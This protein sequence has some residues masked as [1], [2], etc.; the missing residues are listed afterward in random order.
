MGE[1][2]NEPS[3]D[4]P[5]NNPLLTMLFAAV[6]LNVDLLHCA[7]PSLCYSVETSAVAQIQHY[8]RA[9]RLLEL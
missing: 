8:A 7:Q 5:P 1:P 4:P 6:D 9:A 3:P 2:A